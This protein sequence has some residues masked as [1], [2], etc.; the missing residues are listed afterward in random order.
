MFDQ[1]PYAGRWVALIGSQVVG[2]GNTADEAELAAKHIRPK[3]KPRIYFVEGEGGRKLPFSPLLEQLQPFLTEELSPVYLVGG[4]VRD[5]LLQRTS[6]DLDFVVARDAINL[7]FRVANALQVPAYILDQ[8]RETGRVILADQATT[9]DFA[10]FRGSNLEA[11][12]AARDFT[13]NALAIPANAQ[14]SQSIIDPTGGVQ[15]LKQGLIRLTY[16]NAIRDDPVRSL[17]AVRLAAELG[18]EISGDTRS[19]ILTTVS[20][21]PN[22]SAERIRDELQKIILSPHPAAAL[23]Q[24][25][26]L[27]LLQATLPEIAALSG[28]AQSYPHDEDVFR[29]TL[30]VIDWLV[31]IER[32]LLS[33][34]SGEY[35]ALVRVR[36]QFTPY[37][38]QLKLYLQRAVHG[39][40]D[41]RLI[42]RFGALFH[43]VGKSKTQSIAE[44]GR[45]RFFG[46]AAKGAVLAGV[47]LKQLCLSK[48][49]VNQ[50]KQIVAGHMRPL[51]LVQAQGGSPSRRAV[52]RYF[53]TTGQ[54]GLDIGL[55]ALADHLA[56]YDG[57]GESE[58]W[59]KLVD[60]VTTLFKYYFEKHDE[61]VKPAPL[62]SGR[63][64]IALGIEQGPDIGRILRLIEEIQAAGEISTRE[65]ALEFARRQAL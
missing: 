20:N 3:E 6:H 54:N 30:H 9:L 25:D 32:I 26:E 47:R 39:G 35:D 49:A 11:D 62:L 8:K 45:I 5:A 16:Q 58:V 59:S 40:I 56:T 52:Y 61:A 19:A 34:D 65:E 38:P 29:H 22:V 2:V 36:T 50:V 51:L 10:R 1:A 41:G 42:L 63:D 21:L 53:R 57:P 23:Q 7:S 60:L 46:H 44:D 48:D 31:R 55:L 24:L 15:D 13:I 28:V 18:F 37:L 17:R 64:L 43:D 14:T 27:D 4:A 12:L 33:Q